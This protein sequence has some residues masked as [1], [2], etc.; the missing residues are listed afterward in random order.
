MNS[1][2]SALILLMRYDAFRFDDNC[3]RLRSAS[4]S[5]VNQ[6]VDELKQAVDHHWRIDPNISLELA[7]IIIAVGFIR[8]ETRHIAL[9]M[10]ARGDAIRMLGGVQEAWDNLRLAGKL[11]LSIADYVGWARTR[12][13]RM[14]LGP[15][16][17]RV[18]MVERE[19]RRARKIFE[20]AGEQERAFRLDIN[21]AYMY[22]Q[23]GHYQQALEIND[24]ALRTAE[25]LGEQG[26][27]F[28]VNIYINL[29]Y[30]YTEIGNLRQALAY[31]NKAY[32]ITTHQGETAATALA[33]LNI[34]YIELLQGRY[35]DALN[36]LLWVEKITAGNLPSEHI[37]ARRL[38]VEC[39]RNLN[40]YA[41][42]RD[43]ARQVIEIC[44][45]QGSHHEGG[46]TLMDLAIAEAELGHYDAALAALDEVEAIFKH[47]GAAIWVAN[48]QL[49]RGQIALRQGNLEVA[50]AEAQACAAYFESSAEQIN[51]ALALLLYAQAAF[52]TGDTETPVEIAR[53]ILKIAHIS[54]V[55]WL[56][57]SSHFLLA[58]I[59]ESL[60]N[61]QSAAR[62]YRSAARTIEQVQRS[63]TMTL[64]PGFL[65]NKE[66]ALR[67]LIKLY[68]E[69]NQPVQ[70]F[71]ALERAKSQTVLGHLI[72]RENLRWLRNDERSQA[73]IEELENLRVDHHGYYQLAFTQS[74][75]DDPALNKAS[76]EQVRQELARCEAR[77]R[78]ITEQLYLQRDQSRL[79]DVN[80]PS[81]QDMQAKIGADNLL[82]AFYNDSRHL[83]AFLADGHTLHVHQLPLSPHDFIHTLRQLH[84]D[85]DCALKLCAHLGPFSPQ[86]NALTLITRYKLRALYDGLFAP[87]ARYMQGKSR[88][89]IV[90]YGDLHYLPF[91]LLH[92][93]TDYLAEAHELVILP[94]AG[95]LTVPS[96]RRGTHSLVL[97]H[98][99]NGKLPAAL[100]EAELVQN[101]LR[102]DTYLNQDARRQ[103]LLN[104][105]GQVLHIAA[106]G[107][108]RMDQP[109]LS[110]I[111][112]ADGQLYTDDLLQHDLSY[113]LVTLSACETGRARAVPG[114]ELV[115][116]GRGFL[117]A[118]AGAL[119][120]SLW[121]IDDQLT[122]HFMQRLYQGLLAGTSKAAALRDAQ[123][124]FLDETPQLHP[125]FWGAFQLIGSADPLS[126]AHQPEGEFYD[127]FVT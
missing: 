86:A 33:Q 37:M 90:P 40:R 115:G 34:A 27:F 96:P 121:R 120:T 50:L 53:T 54:R 103:H 64:R 6:L 23:I 84:F 47:S 65:E 8:Q 67:G 85:I 10:M 62:R 92:D 26:L 70:A 112:L 102:A 13:G 127:R 49:R 25:N 56:R 126:N 99:H 98:S 35:H 88:L 66:D 2:L 11:Y 116:I 95:L 58:R 43:L 57:Y 51:Y 107:H 61:S 41:E 78:K 74:R 117:Y 30:I 17:E 72:N 91:H 52:A 111:E 89:T 7:N 114:D 3:H 60:G 122:V 82:I 1:N 81:V 106:H 123:R 12:I 20:A 80:L 125:A 87:L 21:M 19:S 113:E 31:H 79:Q 104:Q 97:A 36:K 9:G 94:S 83:W 14:P 18:S 108:Y 71:E 75:A 63:L 100:A 59:A 73:L 15:L 39:Y 44:R 48:V 105:P 124:A 38:I 68:L 69:T 45:Q 32:Q 28:Q 55:P 110:Y 77:M 119:I 109:D 29:G 5:D 24:R 76:Q 42:V 46:Y 118:G 101:L 22:Q 16:L 93:G 4:A